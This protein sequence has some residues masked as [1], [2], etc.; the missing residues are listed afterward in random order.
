MV[1]ISHWPPTSGYSLFTTHYSL[2]FFNL[3]LFRQHH[4]NIISHRIDP[5]ACLALQPR[6]ARRERDR[7]LANRTNQN[8][9]Q[10]LSKSPCDSPFPTSSR[11]L[12][13]NGHCI[14]RRQTRA[15]EWDRLSACLPKIHTNRASCFRHKNY[16]QQQYNRINRMPIP[17]IR[18][19][20]IIQTRKND[21][22]DR[23][24]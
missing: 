24:R 10:L 12:Q 23:K 8:L 22:K 11:Q 19:R 16:S 1:A 3:R 21:G 4:R 18:V 20:Q 14:K 13:A 5:P 17:Q 9:Q 7:R 15:T 6:I 2:R